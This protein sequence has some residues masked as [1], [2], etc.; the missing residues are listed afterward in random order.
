ME[1]G[2]VVGNSILIIA[3]DAP[4]EDSELYKAEGGT[5]GSFSSSSNVRRNGA[6]LT[7]TESHKP[8]APSRICEGVSGRENPSSVPK[9]GLRV[10]VI[11]YKLN[12]SSAFPKN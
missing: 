6:G 8:I 4:G 7:R 10:S 11:E 12:G 9:K 3:S 5:E 2:L 1:T